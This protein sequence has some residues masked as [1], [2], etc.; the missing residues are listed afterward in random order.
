MFKVGDEVGLSDETIQTILSS[1][2]TADIEK[3]RNKKGKVLGIFPEDEYPVT[4]GWSD[5]NTRSY[6]KEEEL[7]KKEDNPFVRFEKRVVATS[8]DVTDMI[9]I[10]TSVS[11]DQVGIKFYQVDDFTWFKKHELEATIKAFEQILEGMT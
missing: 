1:Y 9:T 4:V 2:A 10:H 6:Y 7:M 11:G 5:E 3:L 8:V